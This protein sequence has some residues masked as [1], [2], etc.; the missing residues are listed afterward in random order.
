M[1]NG[2]TDYHEYDDHTLA[3]AYVASR[4]A[5]EEQK[6][7]MAAI[8]AELLA[9]MR[10]NEARAL[11]D[12]EFAIEMKAGT[13]TY[14]VGVLLPLM[15]Q[16]PEDDLARAW[17]PEAQKVVPGHWDGGQLNRIERAYG[18]EI[19]ERIRRARV[20]GPERVSVERKQ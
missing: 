6:R 13:P 18:G 15:E 4:E 17:V 14:D 16:L 5:L 20:P 2:T 7:A 1:D 12:A 9:R 10:A 3:V 19:G 8:E 11:P